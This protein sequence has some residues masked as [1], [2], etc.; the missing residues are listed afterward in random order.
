[1]NRKEHVRSALQERISA[2]HFD[3]DW[4]IKDVIAHLCAWQQISI[5]RM[6]RGVKDQE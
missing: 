6:Q 2:P 5:A 4:F 3:F 1:M